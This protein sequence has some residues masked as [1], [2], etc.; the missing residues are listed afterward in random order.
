MKI[1]QQKAL[2][3]KG[4]ILKPEVQTMGEFTDDEMKIWR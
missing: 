2:E 3:Q 4:L 1:V